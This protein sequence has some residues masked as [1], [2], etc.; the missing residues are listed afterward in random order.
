MYV[1]FRIIQKEFRQLF[2]DK[3]MIGM[4]FTAPIV[5]ILVFGFA[6]NNDVTHVP[7]VLVDQDRTAQS[8]RLVDRFLSSGYFEVVGTEATVN[9]VEPWLVKGRA[10]IVLVIPSNFGR[11][12]LSNRAPNIQVIAD[13]T[14][15][16]SAVVGLGYAS[17]IIEQEGAH[18][19]QT[20]MAQLMQT[21]GA[22]S[23]QKSLIS[24]PLQP[25]RLEMISRSWYNPDLRSRWFYLPAI[26]AMV[27][28]LN[29]MVMPSMAVVREKEIGTLEQLIVTPVRPY[30]MIIGKLLPFAL[31]GIVN[32]CLF[33]AVIV[34]LFRVPLRGPFLVLL[35]FTL[36]FLLST[37]G[38]GLLLSTLVRTQQQAMMLSMYAGMVPMIYLSG[39]VFPIENM[40][41]LI[42]KI[43][44]VV[45]L[46]YYATILRGVFLKGSGAD[47]LWPEALI[48][49]I[50]G[51]TLIT[52]ASLRFQKNLD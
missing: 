3:R 35:L 42:Q 51:V 5:Q 14:D 30:Q 16:T 1:L 17:R 10:Q 27:L 13:G 49:L 29:T 41:A 6:A 44:R 28:L 4:F 15:S 18:M 50:M 24:A 25:A 45:P 46:R 37:L 22:V 32:L 26:L 11:D 19:M 8:R 23:A 7:M 38:V 52:I 21:F 40:P 39:L 9:G 2:R 12:L 43:T 34:F 48:L 31:I 36:P 47:I 33:T 20:R